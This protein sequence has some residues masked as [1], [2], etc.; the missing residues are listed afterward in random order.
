MLQPAS[1]EYVSFILRWKITIEFHLFHL[2]RPR[3]AQ[4]RLSTIAMSLTYLRD[5]CGDNGVDVNSE[6]GEGCD[7]GLHL[8]WIGLVLVLLAEK[9][10][11]LED[12]SLVPATFYIWLSLFS[13]SLSVLM[14]MFFLSRRML[15]TSHGRSY[16]QHERRRGHP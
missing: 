12:H 16:R 14:H 3:S 10:L 1:M 4:Q 15:W 2:C 5:R 7:E 6:D 9:T 8:V 11:S 13:C